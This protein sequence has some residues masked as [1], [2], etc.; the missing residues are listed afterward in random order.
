[1]LAATAIGLVLIALGTPRLLAAIVA[2]PRASGAP[3]PSAARLDLEAGL[4]RAPADPAGWAALA[5]LDLA[6]SSAS[7][8]APRA[9]ALS[10]LTGPN[11]PDLL[12]KRLALGLTL[13]PSLTDGDRALMAEQFRLASE[14][15]PAAL[16]DLARRYAAA[17]PIRA[18]L[19][20]RPEAL[21][22]FNALLATR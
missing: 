5:T 20:D 22:R 10:L 19:A 2:V 12:W 3:S 4:A 14:R 6:E 9:L 18:A 1:V 8:R 15:D 17:D 21:A 16:A 11:E 13:W 7:G